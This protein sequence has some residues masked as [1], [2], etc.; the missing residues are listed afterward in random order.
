MP[1][2]FK[3][4]VMSSYWIASSGTF[5][6][7]HQHTCFCELSNSSFFGSLP[8]CLTGCRLY[9]DSERGDVGV[10][11]LTFNSRKSG[12]TWTVVMELSE[13]CWKFRGHHPANYHSCGESLERTNL[14]TRNLEERSIFY[15]KPLFKNEKLDELFLFSSFF[16]KCSLFVSSWILLLLSMPHP[17]DKADQAS[18]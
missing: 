1:V 13:L 17:Q 2:Y 15:S 16:L 10:R 6:Y 8:T 5:S 11:L 9:V 4:I 12:F 7:I 3:S 14:K 18:N